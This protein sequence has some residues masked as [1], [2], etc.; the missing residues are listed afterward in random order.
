MEERK[1]IFI[2]FWIFWPIFARQIQD[3]GRFFVYTVIIIIIALNSIAQLDAVAAAPP[4]TTNS[5]SMELEKVVEA[6]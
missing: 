5:G 1:F 2:V 3:G 4:T 6:E